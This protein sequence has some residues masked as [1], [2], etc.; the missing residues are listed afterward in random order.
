[1]AEAWF[2]MRRGLKNPM[3]LNERKFMVGVRLHIK[4]VISFVFLLAGI[5]PAQAQGWQPSSGHA[6]MALW[7]GAVPDAKPAPEAESVRHVDS[8]GGRTAGHGS[9]GHGNLRLADI[10][11]HHLCPRGPLSLR[12]GCGKSASCK[13]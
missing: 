7:P 5:A 3:Y 2:G 6:Q 1:M 11:R 10:A 4:A 9:G 8:H 12:T 13:R